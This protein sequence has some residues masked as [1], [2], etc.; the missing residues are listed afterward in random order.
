MKPDAVIVRL[1]ELTLK[2]KN[3]HKF[4]KSIMRHIHKALAPYRQ[5]AVTTE[6]ARVYIA[7][8]G[9][10]YGQIAASLRTVF[11]ISSY[12]PAA[13]IASE[14][15]LMRETALAVFK[16]LAVPPRSF[17]ITAKRA[18][19]SFP[20]DSQQLAGDIGG[21]VLQAINAEREKT[22]ETPLVVDVRRP[23]ADI[24]VDVRGQG[25]YVF[26]E[27]IAS[28]GGF[29][30]GSNGKAMLMLS[31]GI[32]S[33][34][35]G[36]MA[37]RRGLALEAVH[38]HSYPYTSERA[39][40][41]VIE[42]VR[43]LSDFTPDGMKLHLVPFTDIQVRLRDDVPDNL[44]I[45]FMKRAMLQLTERLA[46]RNRALAVVTGE[47][48]GQVASQT[49]SN[50]HVIGSAGSL[51]ILRPLITSD[52][53]EIIDKAL[54]IGTYETSILPYEDCCTLFMPKSPS[55]N[56]S[57]RLIE[58]VASRLD[59]L[60]EAL[61]RAVGATESMQPGAESQTAFDAYF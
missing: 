61:D 54:A 16:G 13:A 18:D 8:N 24:R 14:M 53:Q 50:L 5:V 57:L 55:T 11:G 31:G 48:L 21:Y 60:D 41:K 34:V 43:R 45:T 25:T 52:K 1:G 12:S 58:S 56:P 37:M 38:F 32:D 29:P 49:L 59:W 26:A 22:G 40:L 27:T 15:A 28:S 44:L 7:L 2:G 17:R 20:L 39:K 19:K 9:E 33:P 10:N 23:D 4:E 47:S 6:F 30:H 3:R 51:P 46:E 36:W 42:L 35:A